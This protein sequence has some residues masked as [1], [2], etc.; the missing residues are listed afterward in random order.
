M[1]ALLKNNQDKVKMKSRRN[2]VFPSNNLTELRV[3]IPEGTT[4]EQQ[5]RSLSTLQQVIIIIKCPFIPYFLPTT[6]E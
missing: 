6:A 2:Y 3:L 4:I 1:E 5:D